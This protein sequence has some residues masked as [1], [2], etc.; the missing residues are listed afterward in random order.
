MYHQVKS[1]SLFSER[2]FL[3]LLPTLAGCNFLRIVTT[4]MQIHIAHGIAKYIDITCSRC[5]MYLLPSFQGSKMNPFDGI[6]I[7]H[8]LFCW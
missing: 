7:V 2:L 6:I 4:F 8:G 3:I 1:Y 5:F